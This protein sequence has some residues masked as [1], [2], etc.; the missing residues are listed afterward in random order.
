M[1]PLAM[2]QEGGALDAIWRSLPSDPAALFVLALSALAI[3]AVFV[4]GRNKG[5]GPGPDGTA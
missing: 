1:L 5:K 3:V 4:G 2:F